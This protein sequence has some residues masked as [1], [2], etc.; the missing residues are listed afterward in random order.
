MTRD[1]HV[2]TAA[3]AITTGAPVTLAEGSVNIFGPFAMSVGGEASVI[4]DTGGGDLSTGTTGT[5]RGCS[6]DSLHSLI[7]LLWAGGDILGFLGVVALGDDLLK[8]VTE[9]LT[10]LPL[11]SLEALASTFWWVLHLSFWHLYSR[12]GSM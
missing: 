8:P 11:L 1:E 2:C 12:M 10:A 7:T 6:V 5:C 4:H 9:H 3:A